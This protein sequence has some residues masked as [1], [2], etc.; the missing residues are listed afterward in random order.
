[1][2]TP[3]ADL[4]TETSLEP[5]AEIAQPAGP[6]A[7]L[8]QSFKCEKCGAAFADESAAAVHIQTCKGTEGNLEEPTPS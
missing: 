8:P 7:P 3:N 1:M 6:P 4:T 2:S 5:T